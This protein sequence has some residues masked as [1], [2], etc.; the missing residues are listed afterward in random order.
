MQSGN[1]KSLRPFVAVAMLVVLGLAAAN[2]LATPTMIDI[3]YNTRVFNDDS[4]SVLS[5]SDTWPGGPIT[6]SDTV[7]DGDGAGGEWANLHNW[8]F[9]ADG[10][11]D[12]QLQNDDGFW[13]FA[14]LT[15]TGAR[16]EA[17]LQ[18]SPWW[19]QNVDGRLQVKTS[20]LNGEIAAF[21]GRLPFYSFTANHGITY[22]TGDTVTLGIRYKPNGLSMASPGQIQYY[23]TL[24]SVD[25]TSGPIAFSEGNPAEDPPHGVWGILQPAEVGGVFQPQIDVGNPANG[26]TAVWDNVTFVPE[27]ATITL[28]VL[29]GLAIA[30]RRRA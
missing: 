23:V 8:R 29:G 20:D 18:V 3:T 1:F 9:S 22:T 25:Y 24:N 14:D 7:L 4:N 19:S 27:P 11:D 5:T 10:L 12:A 21:G 6:I 30:R 26:A 15:L 16:A 2:A 17:G 13:M 28:L